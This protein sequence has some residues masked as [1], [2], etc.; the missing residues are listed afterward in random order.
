VSELHCG[1]VVNKGNATA[2]DVYDLIRHVQQTIFNQFGIEVETE[3]K[4]LGEF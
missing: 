4:M 3:V 1:F 2:R